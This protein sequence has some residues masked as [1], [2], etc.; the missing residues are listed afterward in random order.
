MKQRRKETDGVL[1]GHYREGRRYLPPMLAVPGIV[2]S[3]WARD[4]LPD[5]LWPA[6]LASIEGDASLGVW[7]AIQGIVA[8]PEEVDAV[9]LDGRLTS[10]ERIPVGLRS[11]VAARL[12]TVDR[13]AF[14]PALLALPDLYPDLPGAWLFQVLGEK[15]PSAEPEVAGQAMARALV[16]VLANGDK[17]A[18]TKA[19][20][21]R[22][23]LH[24]GRLNMPSEVIEILRDYPHGSTRPLAEATIRSGWLAMKSADLNQRPD[25]ADAWAAWSR[26]FWNTNRR[27]SPCRA[28]H[29]VVP[30]EVPRTPRAVS[31]I[32]RRLVRNHVRSLQRMDTDFVS[33][34]LSPNSNLDI[35]A[36]VRA[37][38]VLGL[39]SRAL[40]V[41]TWLVERPEQWN[42]EECSW[43]LR[44]LGETKILL[45]WMFSQ[46]AAIFDT[47]KD[48]G[49]G[50]RK[51]QLKHA[52]ALQKKI[53]ED[54][55][56]GYVDVLVDS[57]REQTGGDHG[58]AFQSVSVEPTFANTSL[59]KMAE[60]VGLVDDYNFAVQPTSGVIHGE[61]WALEDYC[62]QPCMNVL[63]LFHQ[64]PRAD[65]VEPNLDVPGVV[66]L[67]RVE[68]LL[69]IA[70]DG[71]GVAD[72]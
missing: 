33:R 31:R 4:D 26:A 14:P 22:W 23:L 66:L 46:D 47:F 64:V 48:F 9:V 50:K 36:P 56:S 67:P 24:V 51:L 37:D 59:R 52:E 3:D 38:V 17:N 20:R 6:L 70:L 34:V 43:A 71:L 35:H 13:R 40:R 65:R 19:P 53:G 27:I 30:E 8:L 5:L 42:G 16:D 28:D 21:I 7:S 72:E 49:L 25:L 61:Y 15:L 68:N 11:S 41:V 29:P 54:G 55:E 44:V 62:L 58:D 60:E 57:L 39:V 12:D 18:L 10:L 2:A 69:E 63:H 32:R 1:A 45:T